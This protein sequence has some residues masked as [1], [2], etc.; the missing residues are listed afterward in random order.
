MA[1]EAEATIGGIITP[2]SRQEAIGSEQA[3]EWQEAMDKEYQSLIDNNTWRLVQR[4]KGAKTI[5]SKWTFKVKTN[6]D[7]SIERYKARLLAKGFMQREGVKYTTTYAPVAR[8]DSVRLLTALAARHG[9]QRR[10]I[11]F[12]TA[13]L[14][15]TLSSNTPI[16]MKQPTGFTEQQ[17]QHENQGDESELVCLL[18]KGIYGLKQAGYE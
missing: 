15:S 5:S 11:D 9:L 7:G 8:M 1:A 12:D 14:N 16:Y 4:P 10:S 17:S 3:D 18:L 2:T 13:Y 6:Q